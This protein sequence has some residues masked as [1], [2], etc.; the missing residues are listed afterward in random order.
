LESRLNAALVAWAFEDHIDKQGLIE[1]IL[2]RA[3][4]IHSN[5][6]DLSSSATRIYHG[7]PATSGILSDKADSV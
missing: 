1:Q 2:G 7:P 5:Q 3:V 6:K 4:F